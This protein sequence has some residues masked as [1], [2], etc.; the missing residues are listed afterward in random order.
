MRRL[1]I[2]VRTELVQW[3]RIRGHAKPQKPRF[4]PHFDGFRKWS[5]REDAMT[6]GANSVAGNFRANRISNSRSKQQFFRRRYLRERHHLIP[7][8]LRWRVHL[9]RRAHLERLCRRCHPA[10][11]TLEGRSEERRVGKE[12]RCRVWAEQEKEDGKCSKNY[13]E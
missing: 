1:N 12:C 2:P 3:S 13:R 5:R 7:H 11:R 9:N 10:L 4:I 6:H 8:F